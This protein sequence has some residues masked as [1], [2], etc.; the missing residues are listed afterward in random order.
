MATTQKCCEQYWT[1]PGGNTQQSSSYMATYHPS[2]KLPKLNEPDAGR[3]WRSR[4]MLISDVLWW[5]PSHGQA[6]ACW[7]AWTYIQQLCVDTEYSPE[8]LPEAMNNREGWRERV[9]DIRADGMTRWDD[10]MCWCVCV[11]VKKAV[12]LIEKKDLTISFFILYILGTRSLSNIFMLWASW[13]KSTKYMYN[14]YRKS[15]FGASCVLHCCK[16]FVFAFICFYI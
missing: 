2:W 6:K 10:D 11:C 16:L 12:N 14:I 5:T 3:S 15:S 7:P 13:Y 9:R 4:G 8:D 1:N